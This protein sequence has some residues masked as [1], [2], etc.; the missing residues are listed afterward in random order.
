V[1]RLETTETPALPALAIFS[2]AAAA[3]APPAA[4]TVDVVRTA[5][6]EVPF[7]RAARVDPVGPPTV[8]P[9]R[10]S[11]TRLGVQAAVKAAPMVKSAVRCQRP[12]RPGGTAGEAATLTAA[13]AAAA[14]LAGLRLSTPFQAGQT[15]AFCAAG[16]AVMEVWLPLARAQAGPAV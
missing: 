2:A 16:L 1:G 8:K 9:E 4:A 6:S 12:I 3:A 5:S 15:A 14:V 11:G 13:A 7:N 10:M